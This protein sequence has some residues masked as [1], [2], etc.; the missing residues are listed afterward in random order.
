[1]SNKKLIFVFK[2]F[3]YI[4][5]LVIVINNEMKTLRKK[6]YYVIANAKTHKNEKSCVVPVSMCVCVAVHYKMTDENFMFQFDH[7]F[8]HFLPHHHRTK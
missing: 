7:Q 2:Y 1:M 6:H 3:P 5:F 4:Q 8:D